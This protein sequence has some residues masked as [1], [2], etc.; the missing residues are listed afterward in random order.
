ML[1][2][3]LVKALNRQ[4]NIEFQAAHDYMAMAAYCQQTSY[5][6]FANFFLQQ[7]TEER[8]HGMKVYTYLNDKGHPAI[9]SEI[10]A[11]KAQFGSL[12]ETFEAALLQERKVTKSYYEVYGIA[13]DEREYQ[14]LSFLNWFLDEQVE[15]ESTFETHIDYLTRIKDDSNALYIYEQELGKRKAGE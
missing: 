11:P 5:D 6:G 4:M 12:V 8:V 10:K 3:K 2:E 13:Q 1:S 7:A 15:E 14:T 9:F